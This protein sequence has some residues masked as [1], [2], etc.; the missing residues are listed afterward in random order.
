VS[1]LGPFAAI[2]LLALACGGSPPDPSLLLLI[3]V[4]TLRADYL[5]AYGSDRDLTPSMDALAARSE[6]FA[7]AYAPSA[8][9]L[10]STSSVLTGRYPTE[11]G[12]TSNESSVPGDIP[13]LATLL[14]AR[15]WRTA[16][17]VSN[18]VLREASGLARG[19]DA[20]DDEFSQ[21]E[22]VRKWPERVAKN[23]TDDAL[24]ILDACS[25]TPGDRCFL[26]VHYQDPHG[27]YTPPE[28]EREA[29]IERERRSED[30]GL[31]LEVNSDQ[32]GH[33]GIPSYQ[34]LKGRR[35]VAFYRAGYAAEIRT[36]D[37][38]L[39]RLLAGVEARGLAQESVV[40]LAADH[41]ESLGENDFW[42]AHGEYLDDSLVR[43]P[44]MIARADGPIGV[45]ED[46]VGLVDL[47]PTLLGLVGEPPPADADFLGRDLYA[48]N[49]EERG[50]TIYLANLAGG[51]VVRFGLVTPEWKFVTS[52]RDGVWDARLSPLGRESIDL[53][54][55]APQVVQQM[56]RELGAFQQRVDRGRLER[57]QDL[58]PE[59]REALEALGYAH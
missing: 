49:A 41:G 23:T 56:R 39:G 20:Y 58:S 42:F 28:H 32:G 4:D 36:L 47:M 21:R 44:F 26:W 24:A 29:L 25:D 52:M 27:P 15:G 13:T 50:S 53:T 57:T 19:F 11:L 14:Q 35:D 2:A 8:F 45:R 30:G 37:R 6:V 38:E 34:Y 43:V 59:D 3:T 9:T 31:R 5:G 46:V 1:R 54:A 7:S 40:V 22:A 16:A 17:V 18:F 55:A 33:G 51:R 12:L 10:P 48:E